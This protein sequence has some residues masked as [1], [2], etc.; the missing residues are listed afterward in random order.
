MATKDEKN[1]FYQQFNTVADQHAAW[2]HSPEGLIEVIKHPWKGAPPVVH[3]DAPYYIST[4]SI[5][6]QLADR[7]AQAADEEEFAA[8]QKDLDEEVSN[9]AAFNRLQQKWAI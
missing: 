3:V 2:T 4:A 9:S 8:V 7:R 5:L 1:Q 6:R